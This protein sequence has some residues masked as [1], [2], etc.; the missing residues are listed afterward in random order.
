[1]KDYKYHN[2][3][4]RHYIVM[5]TFLSLFIMGAGSPAMADDDYIFLNPDKPLDVRVSDLLSHLTLDEKISLLHQWQP[6]IPRLGIGPFRTGTEG[7]HGAAWLDT[8][9]VFPQAIGLGAT[10]NRELVKRI[11]SA[12]A[13]EIR[14]LHQ[15]DPVTVGL[16]VWAPVVDLL[17]DPRA[18]RTEEGYSEDAFLTGDLSTAYCAGLKGDDPFYYKTVP[19]L[20]HFYAYNQEEK[21]N[22]ANVIINDRNKYEY[23]LEA[24]RYAIQSGQA[25]SMMTAYNLVN[26]LPCTVHSDVN[27]VVKAKWVPD[28]FFV[29]SDAW[30][31]AALVDEQ[32]YYEDM[33]HAIAG[34][35]LAGVDSITL[36]SE[37][38][39]TTIE[40][41]K[42]AL[43]AELIK[44]EDIDRAVKN[45][46]RVRFHTGEF[47]PD[48]INPYANIPDSALCHPD[49]A[50]LA[51]QAARQAVVLLKNENGMLPLDKA[52]IETVAVIGPLADQV[53][54][55]FYSAPF[56]YAKTI[57]SEVEKKVFAEK[58]VFSRG[59]DQIALKAL[60][61]EKYVS[62][63]SDGGQL[64]ANA[65]TIGENETFDLYDYGWGQYLFRSHANDKYL[66][67]NMD[68]NAIVANV[69]DSPGLHPE[70]VGTQQ[71][72]TYQNFKYDSLENGNYAIYNYQVS[73]WDTGLDGGKYVSVSAEEPY[74]LKCTQETIGSN[75]IF[76]QVLVVNG[77][78]EA[79]DVA[80][81]SDMAIVVVGDEPMLNSRETLDRTDLILPPH[82]ETLIS[83][84]A[85]VNPNT[86]V[87]VVSSCPMAISSVAKNPNIKA[88]LYS[89]HG[90]QEEGRAIADVLF[91]DYNPA[92]RLTMT[93]YDSI[94][95]LPDITEYDIIEGGRT[96]MY[97]KGLPLYPFGYGL[98]YSEFCYRNLKLN[99][100]SIGLNDQLSVTVEIEN[101]SNMA[102][103]EVVQMYVQDV[104]ASVKR[105]E[106]ELLG[107]ERIT[108]AAGEKR[109]V[110]FILPADELAF[111]NEKNGNFYIEPGYYKVMIG[112]SSED[113]RIA[114]CF[115]VNKE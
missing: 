33:P 113:I 26:D 36:D 89:A 35:L 40:Y 42:S 87:V 13:D 59:L 30:A 6:S 28:D 51:L 106:K 20:K 78:N 100:R 110:K 24:F 104:K 84:V 4:Y 83:S 39:G 56:P 52:N 107:F 3:L 15:R 29:V 64:M 44:T 80:A 66:T 21:R 90:G 73:H 45:M 95:Q 43:N 32:H 25:K 108:L 57:L 48:E 53:L 12:V 14:V 19:T 58:V 50:E 18:G 91:G 79:M 109:T 9:T 115:K 38:S 61:N 99:A 23:Y 93:W 22:V 74:G 101:V 97:F 69:A 41:I 76:Q 72:F 10:W 63:P 65:D 55:D 112:S 16:S 67:G 60:T 54:T 2:V 103:D 31:P 70:G 98:S 96:Y 77:L 92:G 68:F 114:Q 17:R 86:I 37:D 46:L 105:P 49:H 11:G 7:L 34:T 75:E 1:M 27:E 47:D 82:Q 71:W 62:A 102:G 5:M 94:D 85:E 88:I 8:A 81:S 111:W